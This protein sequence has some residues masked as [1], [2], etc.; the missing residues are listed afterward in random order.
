VSFENLVL[1]FEPNPELLGGNPAFRTFVFIDENP[2]GGTVKIR[3]LEAPNF[4]MR[5]IHWGLIQR[6]RS[7]KI[8]M[9]YATACRPG[10]SPRK[11]VE[12]HRYSRWFFALDLKSAY[13][14]V[15]PKKLAEIL[16]VLDPALN[17]QQ[18]EAE[19]FLHQY[20]MSQ[21]GGLPIGA[22]AS[23]DFFNRFCA[24]VLDEPLGKLCEEHGWEYTR[25]LDDLTISCRSNPP[26]RRVG[27]PEI[28]AIIE[29]AG[30]Q[31][32]HL[33]VQVHDLAFGPIF[34]NGI[35]LELGGRIFVPQWFVDHVRGLL[36]E[37]L[38]GDLTLRPKI[39]GA[40]GVFLSTADRRNVT[41]TEKKIIRLHQQ[42]RRLVRANKRSR[43]APTLV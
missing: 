23:P 10:D 17:G 30:F 20:C 41:A 8:P 33:K 28:R 26:T 39:D 38:R 31:V 32:N 22:P 3:R 40:M 35:G 14:Q 11:N 16:C 24:V 19:N 42:F 25:Y 36:F 27:R 1:G 43:K 9:P 29:E 4:P 7:L 34:L 6:L 5:V 15:D 2:L 37:G 13:R 21:F 12:H 18:R